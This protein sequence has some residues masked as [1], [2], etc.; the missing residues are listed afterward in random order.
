[1]YNQMNYL[2]FNLNFNLNNYHISVIKKK[3]R[4]ASLFCKESTV[5]VH[6]NDS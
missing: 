4:T 6:T 1:M 2:N 3:K 5:I